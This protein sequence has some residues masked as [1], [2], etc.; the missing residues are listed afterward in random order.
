[1]D[2]EEKQLEKVAKER[3]KEEVK[4]FSHDDAWGEDLGEIRRVL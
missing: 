4:Y 3:D 1:M 2:T